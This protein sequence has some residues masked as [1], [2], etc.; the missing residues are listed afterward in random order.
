MKSVGF[1]KSKI[2][3]VVV[4]TIITFW[5]SSESGQT[6]PKEFKP[7]KGVTVVKARIGSGPEEIGAIAPPEAAPFG[8]MSFALGKGGEIYILDQLNSRVQVFQKGKRTKTIPIPA[9]TFFMDIGL[10]P[11][12]KIVL[13]DFTD[14]KS[15]YI[16][17]SNGKVFNVIPLEGELI[18]S[19]ITVTSIQVVE[20]GKFA[21]IWVQVEEGSVQLASLDGQTT[22]RILAPGKFSL[23]G[24]RLL[25]TQIIGDATA[26]V[27]RSEKDSFSQWEPEITIFFNMYIVHLLGL[28]DDLQERIYLVA[29]LEDTNERGKT[30]YLNGLVILSPEGEELGRCQLFL[31]KSGYEIWHD[32]RLSPEGDLYQLAI[33]GQKVVV[34]KYN[35]SF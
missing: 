26:A 17:D 15:L 25:Y 35:L 32:F 3:T 31:Q 27:Y 11:D 28:W 29:F 4:L 18:S 14:K 20:E 34:L 13:L 6:P 16:L 10:T 12:G 19:A 33:D 24:Q 8:P 21:G 30:R 9:E 22:K 5:P 2:W 1:L 23:N 7:I